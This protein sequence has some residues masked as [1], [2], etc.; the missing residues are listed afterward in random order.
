M[1][2]IAKLADRILTGDIVLPKFQRLFVWSPEQILYLLD[3]VAHNYP[4][5]SVLLWQTHEELASERTVANL[6]VEPS[7]PGYP[8][9]YIID[10]QQRLASIFG[11]LHAPE[12]GTSDSKWNIAY[13]NSSCTYP[14]W[15]R[16]RQARSL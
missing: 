16:W 8:V 5:G 2:R 1:S 6:P 15:T 12:H 13:S 9:N 3:S 11:T 7:P 4:M 14:A 10:G